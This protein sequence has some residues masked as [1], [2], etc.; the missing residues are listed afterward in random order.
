MKQ[1]AS[2]ITVLILLLNVYQGI[3]QNVITGGYMEDATKWN[4]VI[5]GQD[6]GAEQTIEFNYTNDIPTGGSGGCLRLTGT[7]TGGGLVNAAIFQK[8]TIQKTFSYKADFRFKDLSANLT[9]LWFQVYVTNSKP[10]AGADITSTLLKGINTWNGCGVKADGWLSKIGCEGPG[11]TFSLGTTPGDTTVWLAIKYGSGW[12]TE[13]YDLLIDDVTLES[14]KIE[15]IALNCSRA[16][17]GVDQTLSI[18]ALV[19]PENTLNATLTWSVSNET[20]KAT[21]DE[22][23]VLNG[24]AVGKITVTAKSNDGGNAMAS[25]ELEVIEKFVSV[26]TIIVHSSEELNTIST[27]KGTLQMVADITPTDATLK[28][29]VWK[30]I[31]GTGKASISLAGLL[32]AKENGTVKVSATSTDG[33]GISVEMVVNISNQIAPTIYKIIPLGDSKTAGGA[34]ENDQYSWRGLLRKQLIRNDY[35][36]DY[37]GSQKQMAYGDTI[38]Y[39]TDNCGYGGY[40][41]GPDTY[42][43][44]PT[45][46]TIGIYEHIEGW[47]KL[48]GYP[49][50]IIL[51]AGINDL[52]G[53]D[54]DHPANFKAT[55]P[56][57]YR[58]LVNKIRQLRPETKLLLCTVEPVKWDKNWGAKGTGLGNLNDTIRSIA[59]F[60]A[61][62]DIYLADLYTDFIK[63]WNNAFFF[64]EVHLSKL[65]A[66]FTANIIYN[67]ITPLMAKKGTTRASEIEVKKNNFLYFPNP[68]KPNQLL[69][70]DFQG[71]VEPFSL[72]L[73][74]LEGKVVYAQNI[75]KSSNI[76][77]LFPE[78]QKGIYLLNLCSVKEILTNKIVV[79]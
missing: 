14:S 50:I 61:S 76:S 67:A 64:D 16:V 44:C 46:E 18:E 17:V 79:Q 49:D 70:I 19:S 37:I 73:I 22:K 13:S 27:D 43:W 7:P 36:V 5:I 66:T 77:F 25:K 60:S 59:N 47:L 26:N 55:T 15:S 31:N 1:L 2:S 10:L 71:A 8:V 40:T 9:N 74:N 63:S 54:A 38:P 39:D 57:R 33:S 75:F 51:S 23:G 34:N 30:V 69:T 65:G 42:K 52:L 20:G 62:D 72:K 53:N 58:N 48:A 29:V 35:G 78:L 12:T 45:C 21:I 6:A 32:K 41:V 11:L 24:V 28:P 4:Y 3:C 56:Q 68:V